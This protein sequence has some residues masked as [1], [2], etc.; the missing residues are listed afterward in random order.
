MILSW[1]APYRFEGLGARVLDWIAV[2]LLEDLPAGQVVPRR[3][4]DVD[5]AVWRSAAG[6]VQAWGDRCPHRGMRLSHGFVRK[7]K[8][9]CIYHGWQYD[10]DGACDYIPAHPDLTPPK[11]ICAQRHDCSTQDGLIW[12][13]LEA[14]DS[15]VPETGDRVPVRSLDV[16]VSAADVAAML[17]LDL[18]PVLP[19][20]G[21]FDI[22]LAV[23]PSGPSHC[24][25]H[26]VAGSGA[27]PKTVSR[28]LEDL[29]NEWEAAA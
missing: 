4:H 22:A 25:V 27:D 9:A 6:E 29:R 24:L 8:L 23:Q 18:A 3:V 16:A 1:P 7:D 26:A 10:L 13:A 28:H 17:G 12:V 2:A 14:T 19:V 21:P 20:D 15:T 5:L 11:T